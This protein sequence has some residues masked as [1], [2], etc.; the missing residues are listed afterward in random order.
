M[1]IP[2]HF[3][4]DYSNWIQYFPPTA[5]NVYPAPPPA[6]VPSGPHII[7]TS[8]GQPSERSQPLPFM[9]ATIVHSTDRTASCTLGPVKVY[10]N[11]PNFHLSNQQQP[12]SI[13]AAEENT[14]P[15][16]TNRAS[17]PEQ[18]KDASAKCAT[19]EKTKVY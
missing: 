2:V 15:T 9:T 10:F 18:E 8:P 17:R 13:V 19:T 11:V 5:P 1:N 12:S 3:S 16:L 4:G 6:V 14:Q 7:H